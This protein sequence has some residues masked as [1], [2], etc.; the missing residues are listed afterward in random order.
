MNLLSLALMRSP[1]ASSFVPIDQFR[2]AMASFAAGVTIITTLDAQGTPQAATATSFSSVS[3]SPPLCLVCIDRR[4][5]T[6]APLLV[7]GCFAVNILRADQE[8]LS[9]RFASSI[10]DRFA[11]VAWQ[12]GESTGCPVLEGALAS[13][14]CRIAEVHS[15]GDHDIF[16]GRP[17]SVRVSGGSPL[18]YWRGRYRDLPVHPDARAGQRRA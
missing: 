6:H 15:G 11:D 1:M 4:G 9:A 3:M 18:V 17:A 5:R 10:P 14:E 12:P 13:M 8:W 2:D 16:L 7:H